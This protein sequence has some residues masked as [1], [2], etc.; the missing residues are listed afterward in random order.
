MLLIKE[1]RIET[2]A[3]MCMCVGVGNKTRKEKEVD[4]DYRKNSF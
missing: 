2:K 1:G 3:S 4:N